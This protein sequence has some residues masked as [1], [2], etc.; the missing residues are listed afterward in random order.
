MKIV[1]ITPWYPDEK[2]EHAGIFIQRQAQA[3]AVTNDVVVIATKI[4]YSTFSFFKYSLHHQKLNGVNEYRITVSRSIPLFNQFVYVSITTWAA[5]KILKGFKVDIVN[6]FI[7]YPGAILGWLIGGMKGANVVHTEHTRLNNNYRS[8][9]HKSLTRFGMRRAHTLTAV[10]NW[11]ANQLQNDTK[12]EVLVIPNMIDEAQFSISRKPSMDV[13]HIGFLGSLNTNVKG[14]DHLLNAF[15]TLDFPSHLHI[16][17][18]GKLLDNYKMQAKNLGIVDRCTF[19]GFINVVNV[20]AFFQRLHLFVCSSRFET[21]NISLIEA[22]ACGIPVVSTKC[23]GPEDFVSSVNGYLVDTERGE[24][25]QTK[26]D[27]MRKDYHSFSS[28]AIREFVVS[29]FSSS[30]IIDKIQHMYS[31][32]VFK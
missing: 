19:Y 2:Q 29:N 30:V 8:F 15:S 28:F 18:A 22:M 17:G 26:I 9:W 14:L 32:V 27:L 7:G 11:L 23:G 31:R 12:K 24:A 16:G 20:P 10:S 13:F 1:F 4:D 6:S 5:Y 25:L 3:L 21:F